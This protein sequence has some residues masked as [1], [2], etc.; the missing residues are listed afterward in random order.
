[1][2]DNCGWECDFFFRDIGV[3]GSFQKGDDATHYQCAPDTSTTFGDWLSA[4][5]CI[6]EMDYAN[7]KEAKECMRVLAKEFV[8]AGAPRVVQCRECVGRVKWF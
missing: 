6:E 4:V 8:A 2:R 5:Q 1:M 7:I 3:A